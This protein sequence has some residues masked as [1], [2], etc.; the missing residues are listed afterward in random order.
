MIGLRLT[1]EAE[2]AGIKRERGSYPPAP[3]V[4]ASTE[5]SRLMDT[6]INGQTENNNGDASQGEP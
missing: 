3:A 4:A 5:D 2:A 1:A 6:L